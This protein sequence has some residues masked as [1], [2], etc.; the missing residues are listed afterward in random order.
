[1]MNFKTFI[2]TIYLGD[3]ACKSLLLNGWEG[4]VEITVNL[5]S[6]IRDST[7]N[8]NFYSEEDIENGIIVFAGIEEVFIEPSGRFPNDAI[9]HL[10]VEKVTENGVG[11]FR[12][13]AN[14][15]TEEGETHRVI[16][17]IVAKDLYLIDPINPETEL[18]I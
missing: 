12:L 8:W 18:R 15:V 10:V 17:R 9:E 2:N 6:R 1:M 16:V 11:H 5:L 14:Q 3:R 7:G 13:T 4:R